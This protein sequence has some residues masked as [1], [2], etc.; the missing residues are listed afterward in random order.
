MRESPS[1]Q[2]SPTRELVERI[3]PSHRDADEFG[4]HEA[5]LREA[6]NFLLV[7]NLV[8]QRGPT[9]RKAAFHATPLLADLPFSLL[10]LHH[11]QS[12]A[13]ERQRAFEILVHSELVRR[14]WRRA[15]LALGT[16]LERGPYGRLFAW[17][18][19]KL[20]FW[21]HL[22]AHL[23]L[24]H[25]L[26]G[27]SAVAPSFPTWILVESALRWASQRLPGNTSLAD[28]LSQIDATLFTCFTR[29]GRAHRGLAHTLVALH[30]Q[31]RVRLT[32]HSD[33]ARSLM[34]GDWH[35]SS[36]RLLDDEVGM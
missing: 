29:D 23:G 20:A 15:P 4:L 17:T 33:A 2:A 36:V 11:L 5:T 18:G 12:L 8:G 25:R 35:A 3:V 14:R 24:L 16:P 27:R 9:R 34:L 28:H 1:G 31:R 19:E 32:H 21:G 7:A 30:R 22:A 13:D 26:N 6:L 10:L